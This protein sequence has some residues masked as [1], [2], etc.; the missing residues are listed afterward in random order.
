MDMPD[1]KQSGIY[2]LSAKKDFDD[3]VVESLSLE[4]SVRRPTSK[5]VVQAK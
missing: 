4:D 1:E 2:G 3:D 5:P